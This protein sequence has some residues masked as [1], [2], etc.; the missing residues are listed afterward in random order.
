[1]TTQTQPTDTLGGR[2]ELADKLTACLGNLKDGATIAI[3]ADWGAGKTFFGHLWN[4]KLTA[5]GYTTIWL[6]A[7]AMDFA[8]DPFFPISA[9]ILEVVTDPTCKAKMRQGFM[10]VAKTIVPSLLKASVNTG[11]R[12]ATA[13]LVD[14]TV[15][16]N[17]AA[18]VADDMDDAAERWAQAQLDNATLHANA[19]VSL[20][21]Q[22]EAFAGK[23]DKPL[24]IFVDELDR[25]RPDFA[26][27]TI[28]RI[29]HLFEVKN[30]VFVLLLNRPQLVAAIK[31]L[32]GESFDAQTYLQ[33]FILC[34]FTLPRIGNDQ[35]GYGPFLRLSAQGLEE[36]FAD[37]LNKIA[38][39]WP[40][41][42][43]DLER[44]MVVYS[45]VGRISAHPD[46]LAFLIALKV[47]H[48]D[49]FDRLKRQDNT[50]KDTV[51]G[52]VSQSRLDNRKVIREALR[53]FFGGGVQGG[54]PPSPAPIRVDTVR[55]LL[56]SID[57]PLGVN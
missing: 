14:G 43:R 46:F 21:A 9:K 22:I 41:S 12:V 42:L 2:D 27:R 26:I 16:Q 20:K 34:S 36:E 23:L 5:Q 56:E 48:P 4:R 24:I 1:M 11:L 13:G 17:F 53:P 19:V 52:L 30:V 47:K 3:D 39:G 25:C 6:D 57:L 51:E 8:E 50:A 33:K 18:S 10:G 35:E 32:Y 49:L 54:P 44:C 15:I 45:L 37:S 55:G 31:G 40:L 38:R 29:K 7:F 28:E